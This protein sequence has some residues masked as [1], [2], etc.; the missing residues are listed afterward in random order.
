MAFKNSDWK[1]KENDL[2][3]AAFDQKKEQTVYDTVSSYYV[4]RI[5][6]DNRAV[7]PC[8]GFPVGVPA[9]AFAL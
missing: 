8:T 2:C 9:V 6:S 7:E 5:D 3:R 1:D 4:C